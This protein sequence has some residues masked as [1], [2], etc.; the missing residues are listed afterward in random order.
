MTDGD[1][2][3][4]NDDDVCQADAAKI[5]NKQPHEGSMVSSRPQARTQSKHPRTSTGISSTARG[6]LSSSSPAEL[7]A[8]LALPSPSPTAAGVA[9]TVSTSVSTFFFFFPNKGEKEEGK[10]RARCRK[11]RDG[12]GVQLQP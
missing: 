5:T 1:N 6:M 2:H 11:G 9:T 12:G 10:R 8:P 3:G 4:D 7:A